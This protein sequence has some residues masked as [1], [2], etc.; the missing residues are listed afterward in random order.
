[1][2]SRYSAYVLA[3][4]DYLRATWATETCPSDLGDDGSE[5]TKWLGLSIVGAWA[6]AHEREGFVEFIAKYKVGGTGA[7]R[8]H[9]VSRF[10]RSEVDGRWLYVDG[11]FPESD[12]AVPRQ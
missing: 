6:G 10:I 11:V 8:L 1:M 3:L 12:E 9:E 4:Y 7:Q 5:K 2:R